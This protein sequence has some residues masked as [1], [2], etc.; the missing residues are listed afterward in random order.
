M[1]KYN[2]FSITKKNKK[3][4]KISK[5][6]KTKKNKIRKQ[7]GGSEL[8]LNP[9]N[10]FQVFDTLFENTFVELSRLC[11]VD[12][13]FT[14]YKIQ[15]QTLIQFDFITSIHHQLMTIVGNIDI[16]IIKQSIYYFEDIN[17]HAY[18][19]NLFTIY[20]K[21]KGEF[22]NILTQIYYLIFTNI[23]PSSKNKEF[24][25]QYIESLNINF[26]PECMTQNNENCN[27]YHVQVMPEGFDFIDNENIKKITKLAYMLGIKWFYNNSQLSFVNNTIFNS[28]LLLFFSEIESIPELAK[29]MN[30]SYLSRNIVNPF[31]QVILFLNSLN[32]TLIHQDL[33]NF[34]NN[35]NISC[36]ACFIKYIIKYRENS[37]EL[38][39]LFVSK[40]EFINLYV[41]NDEFRKYIDSQIYI[42]L[43]YRK[44]NVIYLL[45]E[46]I[47][48]AIDYIINNI[49][50]NGIG[51]T[52]DWTNFK[53]ENI[54]S[55]SHLF[56]NTLN[57]H[58]GIIDKIQIDYSNRRIQESSNN[59]AGVLL[60]PTNTRFWSCC[61]KWW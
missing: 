30:L 46:E 9:I 32:K 14:L 20:L 36:L 53:L 44:I 34:I 18:I 54:S 49:Q 1:N 42:G 55:E 41:T 33:Y 23:D 27:L 59:Y 16:E 50:N 26:F 5:Q 3:K 4:I 40:P 58:D 35:T 47:I 52:L 61:T 57:H 13:Y 10:S 21:N 6:Q 48:E 12:L 24:Q 22:I 28:I 51:Y 56:Y 31:N 25:Y 11:A 60:R 29:T 43:E 19:N 7:I 45:S 39:S 38:Y 2:K 8:S 17:D 15:T 37:I